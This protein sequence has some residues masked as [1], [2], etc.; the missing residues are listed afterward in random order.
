MAISTSRTK[1]A[2]ASPYRGGVCVAAESG[3]FVF[4]RRLEAAGALWCVS[5][6]WRLSAETEAAGQA[7]GGMIHAP[8]PTRSRGRVS[9]GCRP[10]GTASRV[11]SPGAQ[12]GAARRR[13]QARTP[14]MASG[15][16]ATDVATTGRSPNSGQQSSRRSG[17]R[18]P[19]LAATPGWTVLPLLSAAAAA[20]DPPQ[21]D[22]RRRS[23][24]RAAASGRRATRMR[25][26]RA[27]CS[28][29]LA[30]SRPAS[31]PAPLAIARSLA[32]VLTVEGAPCRARS[33]RLLVP[34][35]YKHR[36]A[37]SR[38]TAC[39]LRGSARTPWTC[40]ACMGRRWAG[41]LSWLGWGGGRCRYRWRSRDRDKVD[42]VKMQQQQ[43]TVL[44]RNRPA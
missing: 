5:K 38:Y 42:S 36:K 11:E 21:H 27:C 3:E 35:Q 14:C 44:S 22:Q 33:T 20:A 2:C 37:K 12:R 40:G 31:T 39:A 29:C 1:W 19:E 17:A 9:V 43:Q 23:A 25:M 6:R 26:Q 8:A 18:S 32:R 30:C 34:M 16:A 13:P 7:A 15:L 41:T 4:L 24:G 10:T 28:R